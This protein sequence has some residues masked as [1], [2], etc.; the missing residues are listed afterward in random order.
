M[1]NEKRRSSAS[2]TRRGFLGRLAAGAPA[3]A[4]IASTAPADATPAE[5]RAEAVLPGCG[6]PPSNALVTGIDPDEY[7]L[8]AFDDYWLPLRNRLELAL[9][10]PEPHEGNPVLRLGK[11]GE[12]DSFFAAMY[13]TVFRVNGEFRM[14]Y[15]AVDGWEE[16]HPG[17]KN[18]RLAYARSDDGIRWEKPALRLR[19]HRGSRDNNLL[20]F[21][22]DCYNPTILYEPDEPDPKRRFKMVY[23]GYHHK[24]LSSNAMMCVA[25]SADGLTWTDHPDNPMVRS[26]WTEVSGLYRWNGIYYANGQSSFSP[27]NFKR[28]MISFASPDLERWEQAGII[29]FY[30]HD[31]EKVLPGNVGP[32][33]H[34]GASIWHRGNVLVGL[35]GAWEGHESNKLND[36]RMNLGLIISN[37][38]MLFREPLRGFPMIRYG[39]ERSGWKTVRLLQGHAFVNHGDRTMIW[40]SAGTDVGNAVENQA[41]VGLATLPRDRFGYLAPMDGKAM[42]VSNVLPPM[43]AGA[44]VAVNAD[45]LG[46]QASMRFELLDARFV[47]LPGYSDEDAA[48]LS[49]SGLHE[50]VKWVRGPSVVPILQ[51]WRLRAHFA[52]E[53]ARSVRFYAMYIRPAR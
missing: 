47:P 36:V 52:G 50:P 17:R 1:A 37:D 6:G 18:L 23:S 48:I 11:P 25:Y 51:P 39:T 41:E 3:V 34:L 53:A 9:Q 14:W 5:E 46:P 10:S 32:Q 49:R 44:K 12:P 35:Y 20:G 30:R 13:G 40:Y 45:G 29:S 31:P 7:V 43:P 21:E 19:E 15:G 22:R 27:K 24:G 42:W 28:T 4:A 8:F 26:T 16:F 38:G 2:M 33:V